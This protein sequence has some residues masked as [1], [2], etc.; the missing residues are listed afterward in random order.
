LG[1]AAIANLSF[2]FFFSTAGRADRS[3]AVIS[4]I[5]L[6]YLV[7]NRRNRMILSLFWKHINW[8]SS[9]ASR[10]I[11]DVQAERTAPIL[12]RGLR[13]VT[14]RTPRAVRGYLPLSPRR[15]ARH[16]VAVITSR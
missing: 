14:Q 1:G 8:N 9:P 5:R 7:R 12:R 10:S 3:R 2:V 6:P 16:C 4:R 15:R 13:R 11:R